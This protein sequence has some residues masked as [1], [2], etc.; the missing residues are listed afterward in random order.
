MP[1][2]LFLKKIEKFCIFIWVVTLILYS[3]WLACT[4]KTIPL[5]GNKN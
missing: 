2:R 4:D 3:K 5:Q 1:N